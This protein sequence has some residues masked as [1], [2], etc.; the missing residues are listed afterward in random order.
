M[1]TY[2]QKIARIAIFFFE[3]F[4]DRKQNP[5][6]RFVG[7]ISNEVHRWA[8]EKP[9]LRTWQKLTSDFKLPTSTQN[10]ESPREPSSPKETETQRKK[11]ENLS[12]FDRSTEERTLTTD[13]N[14]EWK[15]GNRE[16][17]FFFEFSPAHTQ[18]QAGGRPILK[19]SEREF[20]PKSHPTDSAGK[21]MILQRKPGKLF[22]V[23]RIR[24]LCSFPRRK[25]QLSR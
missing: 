18:E 20:S 16:G 1:F 7:R 9:D 4:Q 23:S 5:G 3:A 19:G 25:Q 10:E 15:R 21:P 24:H 11:T 14:H 13:S 22:W 2:N 6:F 8:A 17:T 12:R